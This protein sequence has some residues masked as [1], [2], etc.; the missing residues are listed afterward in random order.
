MALSQQIAVRHCSGVLP[1][2]I[3]TTNYCEALQWSIALWHHHK[4][5]TVRYCSGVC[6]VASSQQNAVRYC[7]VASSQQI[8][9]RHC[10]GVLPCDIITTNCSEVL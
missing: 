1:C 6:L 9:V 4:K 10:S 7:L 3:I 8:A 5:I 2:G